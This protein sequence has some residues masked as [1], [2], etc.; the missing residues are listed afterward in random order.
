MVE[1]SKSDKVSKVEKPVTKMEGKAVDL[2][3]VNKV[4]YKGDKLRI[5]LIVDVLG[6]AERVPGGVKFVYLPSTLRTKNNVI[7]INLEDDCESVEL[8]EK[9][10]GAREYEEMTGGRM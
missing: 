1:K 4:V 5:T 3:E 8:I 10:Q 7:R 9:N 6:E 2:E